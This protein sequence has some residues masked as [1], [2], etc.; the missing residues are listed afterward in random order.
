[1]K[2]NRGYYRK[3]RAK[4]IARKISIQK[5]KMGIKEVNKIYD[6]RRKGQLGKGKIHCSCPMCRTKSY[7]ELSRRDQAELERS[8]QQL[9]EF[10]DLEK[11]QVECAGMV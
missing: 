2:R 10:Y 7:D 8:I 5:K 9:K 11:C 4:F 6:E 1:M 3:Q